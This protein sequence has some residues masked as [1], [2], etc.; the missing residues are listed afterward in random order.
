MQF[1]Q[2]LTLTLY[3]PQTQAHKHKDDGCYGNWAK[4]VGEGCRRVH[5]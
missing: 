3:I 1:L 2:A 5:A 4:I